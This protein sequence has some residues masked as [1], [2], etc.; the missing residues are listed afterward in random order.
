[1]IK[2]G[3]KGDITL[4]RYVNNSNNAIKISICHEMKNKS[5]IEFVSFFLCQAFDDGWRTINH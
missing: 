1:M 3:C 5:I 2:S 4:L